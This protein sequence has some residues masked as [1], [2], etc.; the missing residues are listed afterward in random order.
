MLNFVK[1]IKPMIY[2]S[3]PRLG[4]LRAIFVSI[5][6]IALVLM[7]GCDSSKNVPVA[8]AAP[9]KQKALE[10]SGQSQQAGASILLLLAITTPIDI[11]T[12]TALMG[13]G[14]AI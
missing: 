13:I 2:Q 12:N 6:L 10:P 4:S 8:V 11:S 9:A 7:S 5:F 1:N 14:A 3:P